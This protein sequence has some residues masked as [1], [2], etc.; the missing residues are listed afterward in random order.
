LNLGPY[1]LDQLEA[2]FTDVFRGMKREFLKRVERELSG[3]QAMILQKLHQDGQQRITQIASHLNITTGA[4]TGLCD[5]LIS[6]GYA[7]RHRADSDRRV[8]HVDITDA[9]R[10][11]LERVSALRK[12]IVHHFFAGL[13]NEEIDSLYNIFEKVLLNLQREKDS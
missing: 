7:A 9:G 6:A 5:K 4:V 12:Q 8:V 2:V 10:E 1:T 11:A 3:S 13:S